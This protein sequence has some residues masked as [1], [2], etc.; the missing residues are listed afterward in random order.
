MFTLWAGKRDAQSSRGREAGEA[1]PHHLSRSLL[2]AC[3]C[4]C[5]AGLQ[6]CHSAGPCFSSATHWPC[7]R[8]GEV[9]QRRVVSLQLH[10]LFYFPR[11]LPEA[12]SRPAPEL[13]TVERASVPPCV[14]SGNCTLHLLHLHGPS[15]STS[16]IC[17]WPALR[18]SSTITSSL[19]ILVQ[20]HRAPHCSSNMQAHFYVR[21]TPAIPATVDFH[22]S[23]SF[24]VFRALL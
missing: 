22:T 14:Y 23:G 3:P 5:E 10:Q 24:P 6:R 18:T 8:P 7:S 4:S 13:T 1:G 2:L 17:P 21:F 15:P 16:L 9:R 12:L 19:S 11:K 20:P